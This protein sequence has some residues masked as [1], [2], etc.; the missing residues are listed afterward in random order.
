MEI[1]KDEQIVELLG[2]VHKTLLPFFA[3]YAN[4]KGLMNFDGFSK[5]CHDFGIFPD[6]LTKSKMM[7]FFFTLSNFYQSTSGDSNAS[8]TKAY[9]SSMSMI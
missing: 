2:C 5:F 4:N 1:L 3:F 6:I 7:R 9:Q 8:N